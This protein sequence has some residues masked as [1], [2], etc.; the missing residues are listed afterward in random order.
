M[1]NT[2]KRLLKHKRKILRVNKFFYEVKQS[3]QKGGCAT[4]RN[5]KKNSKRIDYNPI[6]K[7]PIKGI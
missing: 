3:E 7:A 2:R 4:Y 5:F 6:I 1:K